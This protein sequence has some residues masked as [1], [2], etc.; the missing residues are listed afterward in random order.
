[1]ASI[2]GEG[3]SFAHLSHGNAVKIPKGMN[4]FVEYF[5]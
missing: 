2:S 5:L 4:A 1:M 3:K